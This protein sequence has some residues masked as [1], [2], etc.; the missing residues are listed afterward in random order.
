MISGVAP[1][2]GQ[3]PTLGLV[4]PHE[5]NMGP[6]LQLVQVLVMKRY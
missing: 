6:L 5:V 4:E 1:T 2:Q 3:D